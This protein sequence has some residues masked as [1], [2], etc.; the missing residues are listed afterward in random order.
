[1]HT[2]S[3]LVKFGLHI[4]GIW[5]YVPSAVLFRLYWIVAMSTAQ[6]FEYRFVVVNVHMDNFSEYI[7]GVSNAMV[8]SLFYHQARHSV[9][10]STV[11]RE[12]TRIAIKFRVTRHMT[13]HRRLKYTKN[14]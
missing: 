14:K 11:R 10:P 3:R 1:M 2:V 5:P 13:G 12:F 8:S 9:G 4:F 6:V 7:D